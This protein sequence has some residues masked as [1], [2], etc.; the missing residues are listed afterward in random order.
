MFPF[1]DGE[2]VLYFSSDR[3]NGIGGLDIYK[4]LPNDIGFHAPELLPSPV[5]TKFDDFSYIIDIDKNEG[6]FSSK[7]PNGKGDDDI[8]YF[9]K[10]E[11]PS[12]LLASSNE[13]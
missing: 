12:V 5:N 6:Y 13:E 7:R 3:A 10:S 9:T 2:G 1:I 8:Y 11:A 4:A